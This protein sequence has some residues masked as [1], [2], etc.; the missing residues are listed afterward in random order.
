MDLFGDL[1]M[2]NKQ[3]II[4]LD[5]LIYIHI[6]GYAKSMPEY[7]LKYSVL[8]MMTSHLRKIGLNENDIIIVAK[9][10]THLEGCWRHDY[11]TNYKHARSSARKKSGRNWDL[12]WRLTEELQQDL[13]WIGIQFLSLSRYEADDWFGVLPQVI[14]DKE[15]VFLTSDSDIEQMFYYPNVKIFSAKKKYKSGKGAYKIKPDNFDVVKIIAKKAQKEIK[16]GMEKE[17]ET[18]EEYDNRK[19]CNDLISLPAFVTE[20]L[21]DRILKIDMS[22]GYNWEELPYFDKFQ[23][24]IQR[25]YSQTDIIT[26]EACK[27][28]FI[29]KDLAKKKADKEKREAKK[30]EKLNK[31]LTKEV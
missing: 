30:L 4:V 1:K 23:Q 27:Q 5:W 17:T 14:T 9:D 16:D 11:E 31:Q 26:I 28:Y 25:A 22:A 15:L 18:E 10:L 19:L 12:I 20:P 29:K 8:N 21:K 7:G 24:R 6:I 3:K 2:N 13:E